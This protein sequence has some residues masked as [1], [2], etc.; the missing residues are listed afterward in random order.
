MNVSL[1]YYLVED[2][3]LENLG[4][5]SSDDISFL[6][7]VEQLGRNIYVSGSMDLFFDMNTENNVKL[8]QITLV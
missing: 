5:T 8:G 6:F 7:M 1:T 4:E 2:R 3:G